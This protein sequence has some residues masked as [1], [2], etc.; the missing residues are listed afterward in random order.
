MRYRLAK[1]HTHPDRFCGGSKFDLLKRKD[2]GRRVYE[3]TLSKINSI[4]SKTIN[5]IKLDRVQGVR[6]DSR[7]VF[8]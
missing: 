4:L 2:P 7:R 3:S 8:L 6:I 1:S 5:V